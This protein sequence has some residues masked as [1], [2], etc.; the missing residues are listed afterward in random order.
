MKRRYR[1]LP[2]LLPLLLVAGFFLH[3]D[4]AFLRDWRDTGEL[5]PEQLLG[6][7]LEQEAERIYLAAYDLSAQEL[8]QVWNEV[9]NN[10]PDLFF[11]SP[12]YAFSTLNGRVWYV[13]PQYETG[14]AGADARQRYEDA[15]QAAMAGVETDWS[16]LKKALYLHDWVA[17]H[18]T[19]DDTLE[20]GSAYDLLVEGTGVCQAY[21]KGYLALL[22]QC[23]IPCRLVTS[24]EMKHAWVAVKLDGNWYN[25][26]PTYDDPTMDRLGYVQH[27]CFLKSDAALQGSHFGASTPACVSTVYDDASWNQVTSAFVPLGGTFYCIAGNR[28]CRW[29]DHQLAPLYTISDRWYVSGSQASYWD[30]C[31]SVLA[32]GEDGLLFNTPGAIMRYD[33]A[34]GRANPVYLYEGPGAIY[35][36]TVQDGTVTCQVSDSPNE[37][38]TQF[39]FN[40]AP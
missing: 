29:E 35:G 20:G 13:S 28:L 33:L 18:G 3:A 7:R 26:D 6:D 10:R 30:G 40:L 21:A 36:F 5:A 17:L 15:V 19:Y 9:Y 34:A 22:Q 2:V 11:V 14:R 24:E 39:T 16:D 8:E 32:A 12:S 38:G 4:R 1:V 27:T 37:A 25:A 31:F 23:G